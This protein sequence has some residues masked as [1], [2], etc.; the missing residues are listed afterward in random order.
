MH[1]C[2]CIINIP[3]PIDFHAYRPT[4]NVTT[5]VITL[6]L[7]LEGNYRFDNPRPV[8]FYVRAEVQFCGMSGTSVR[9][10]HGSL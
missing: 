1:D 6:G 3:L 2:H 10:L 4:Y 7:L 8:G 5:S 9:V